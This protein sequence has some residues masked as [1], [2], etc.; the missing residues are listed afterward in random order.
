MC[1]GPECKVSQKDCAGVV[2]RTVEPGA[3]CSVLLARVQAR[4]HSHNQESTLADCR[5]S[6]RIA[7]HNGMGDSDELAVLILSG[8]SDGPLPALEHSLRQRGLR[9]VRVPLPMP[10]CGVYW[11]A[12]PFLLL[13]AGVVWLAVYA[14]NECTLEPFV[15]FAILIIA[16]ALV[17]A[18][19]CVA[20][21]VRFAEWHGAANA[22][23]LLA[24]HRV[25]LVVGF[26]WG[27]GIAHRLLA[28]RSWRG[29][30]LLLAPTTVAMAR[31]ALRSPQRLDDARVRVVLASDDGFVPRPATES[32]Y[33]AVA[34]V[35]DDHP[36]CGRAA[37]D[38]I[39]GASA[40]LLSEP[41]NFVS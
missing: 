11:C 38:A 10:P 28:S 15:V 14:W 37:R 23:R 8:W 21:V 36:L 41:V 6:R 30:T 13:L 40:E 32:L 27:G 1:G 22:K 16:G 4:E 2:L 25:A 31:C 19:L 9:C 17:A 24:R 33:E 29:P 7:R 39:V 35:H 12:N 18:R 20:G 5:Q 26:S 34:V 3:Y